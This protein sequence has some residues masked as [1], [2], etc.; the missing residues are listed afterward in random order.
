VGVAVAAIIVKKGI[1]AAAAAATM[2]RRG[3]AVVV[4]FGGK[5][6]EIIRR[7]I[8]GPYMV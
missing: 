1:A 2:I 5:F 8:C 7:T 3:T 4:R 6:K